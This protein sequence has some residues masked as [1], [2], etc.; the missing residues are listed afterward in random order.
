MCVCLV[1][2]LERINWE[3]HKQVELPCCSELV[4]HVA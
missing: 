4:L 2:S 3:L 1:L